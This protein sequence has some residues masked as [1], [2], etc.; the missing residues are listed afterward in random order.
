MTDPAMVTI[1]L[2]GR[3]TL[4]GAPAMAGG[5]RDSDSDRRG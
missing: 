2:L 5:R 4:A 1:A 3:A